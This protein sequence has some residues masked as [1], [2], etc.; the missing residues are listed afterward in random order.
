[1]IPHFALAPVSVNADVAEV[2]AVV[3]GKQLTCVTQKTAHAGNITHSMQHASNCASL[4]QQQYPG[5]A[6]S[7]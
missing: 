5:H 2:V 7:I 4:H 6:L 3:V 1:M